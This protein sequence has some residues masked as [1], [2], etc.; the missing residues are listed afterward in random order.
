VLMLVGDDLN[1]FV[2]VD[3]LTVNG[4]DDVAARYGEYWGDGWYMLPNPT[5]GSW[6]RALFDSDYGLAVSERTDRKAKHLEP[7]GE[8]NE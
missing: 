3:G 4:R 6:E 5:Y 7:K 2:D 8:E 1:D